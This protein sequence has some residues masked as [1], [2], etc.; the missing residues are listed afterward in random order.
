MLYQE[1]LYT[2]FDI[3]FLKK[4]RKYTFL[5]LN[6]SQSQQLINSLMNFGKNR[7]ILNIRFALLTNVCTNQPYLSGGIGANIR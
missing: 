5:L 3:P 1:G 6:S 7:K 2:L 4:Q